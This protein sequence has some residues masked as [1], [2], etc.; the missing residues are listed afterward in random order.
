MHHSNRREVSHSGEWLRCH[1][2]TLSKVV[3]LSR[4][5][6]SNGMKERPTATVANCDEDSSGC[7]CHVQY[8][9]R[10]GTNIAHWRG[11]RHDP[12]QLAPQKEATDRKPRYKRSQAGS[13]DS[14]HPH[15]EASCRHR[16][17]RSALR[18]LVKAGWLVER[19]ELRGDTGLFRQRLSTIALTDQGRKFLQL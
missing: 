18:A 7:R 5:P 9:L 12:H 17:P 15:R 19:R 2:S 14:A 3:P 16:A 1:R 13:R 4:A 10:Y 11:Q 8:Q 6:Q